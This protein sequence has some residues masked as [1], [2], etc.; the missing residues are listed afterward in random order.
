MSQILA[1]KPA[2]GRIV[3]LHLPDYQPSTSRE[4]SL[5]N[6]VAMCGHAIWPNGDPLVPYLPVPLREALEWTSLA[7]S[8]T[9]PRPTWSWCRPCIGHAVDVHGMQHAVLAEIAGGESS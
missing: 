3:H 7:P 8:V 9:D 2:R 1:V 4:R 6:K 5:K